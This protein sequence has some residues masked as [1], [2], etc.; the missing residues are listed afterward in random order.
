MFAAA[1]ASARLA[2]TRLRRCL[3]RLVLI[4][5]LFS[6]SPVRSQPPAAKDPAEVTVDGLFVTVRNP[7]DTQVVNR[8]KA[9]T[10][11]FLDRPDHRGL[12]IVYD[13]NPDGYPSSTADYGT[14][15]DLAVFLLDL[16]DITTVAFVHNDVSGHAVL[17]VLACKEIAMS[18]SAKL[19]DALRGQ[20]RPLEDDQLVFYKT[21]AERRRRPAAAVLRMV[22]K[23][24]ALPAGPEG[25]TLFDV[26]AAEKLG[27]CD[28]KLETRQEVKDAYRLPTSSLREDPLQ[29]R[30]PNAWRIVLSGPVTRAMK[31]T[32]ER[33][34]QRAIAR[35]ANLIIVQ[36]ECHGGDTEVARDLADFLRTRRDDQ[37]EEPVMTVAF[38]ADQARDTATFLALGC[39]EIV[40]DANASLGGFEEVIRERPR[41]AEAIAKSLEDLAG[42]QGYPPILARAMLLNPDRAIY[43]VTAQNGRFT[44]SRLMDEEEFEEDQRGPRRWQRDGEPVK[45]RGQYLKLDSAKARQLDVAKFVY[46]GGSNNIMAWFRDRYGLDQVRDARSDWLDE[47]ARFLCLP[48]VSVF[49][50]MIGITGLVLELKIPGIGLPGVI[51]ALCFVLYFWA[52]HDGLRGHLTML[53]VLLFVLGLILIA[54]EIFVLP[55]LGVTGISG[56]VLIVVSLGLVTLVKKP[57][58]TQEW[59]EFGATLTT[60]G[61]CL[62]VSVVGAMILGWYLPSIPYASRLVL[63]PPGE[64]PETLADPG[65]F[66]EAAADLLG[67]IGQAATDLRPAGKARFGEDY[68]DVVA[69]GSYVTAG[70]Q[71]QVVDVTGNR[72]VVKVV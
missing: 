12:K 32:M 9:V 26:A 44:E 36:L 64:D 17:P 63:I 56:I 53:A 15:R 19:G 25:S 18:R 20:T 29:G 52:H 54:L 21:V 65:P 10:T 43:R 13:F 71:V 14:C 37:G 30:S 40:M 31:E 68:V 66:A 1:P 6:L 35:G 48:A 41:Y 49:L 57:E 45:A 27:L 7:I 33:R 4:A 50:V 23:H 8:V 70:T 60:L 42:K 3:G 47:I 61:L 38:V 62:A 67:A 55:G 22:D 69:E 46:E 72:V 59:V 5:C 58:T 39:S 11:R 28:V 16:Q 24:V 2:A 34:V 51:A